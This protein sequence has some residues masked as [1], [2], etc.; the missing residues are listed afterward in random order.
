MVVYKKDIDDTRVANDT[1]LN[2][3]KPQVTAWYDPVNKEVLEMTVNNSWSLLT[4]VWPW[5]NNVSTDI[6]HDAWWRP[7]TILDK[8]IFHWLW[9]F[10][11]PY[12]VWITYEDWTEILAYNSTRITSANWW[13]DMVSWTTTWNTSLLKS[14]RNPRYQPNRW[15]LYSTAL[16]ADNV[17]T[18]I[19]RWWIANANWT[20]EDW[21]F[22]ELSWWNLYAVIYSEWVEFKKELIDTSW[23]QTVS[24]TTWELVDF[25]VTKWNL[26][27]IQ[28]QWRWVWDYLFF[29]NQKLVHVIRNLWTLT[30]VS[31]SNPWLSVMYY[32]E[33]TDWT[34]V[35]L[36]V[37]CVDVTSEWWQLEW[38][39]YTWI[40]NNDDVSVTSKS[41][42][43]PMI[44]AFNRTSF[45]WRTNTRDAQLLRVTIST[46]QDARF[47]IYVTRDSTAFTNLVLT[48]RYNDSVLQYMDNAWA[49]TPF[50]FDTTKWDA[51]Y[52]WTVALWNP[53]KIEN[54]IETIQFIVTP[55]DYIVVL[56]E[57]KSVNANMSAVMEF[58]EEI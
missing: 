8:S 24:P 34:E 16:R 11:V 25:D 53:F 19:R 10:D 38:L 22:F 28:F 47:L 48:D 35:S 15:H 45:K 55:W 57:K 21:T 9:T 50:T 51:L 54:P 18:W 36:W 43:V 49:A 37:W 4:S 1:Y 29:I 52:R 27:D 56:W 23:I 30:N 31:I 7:K 17:S 2:A 58:G 20:L 33:N 6:A 14:R 44:A 42:P 40:S 39:T 32:T 5:W 46:D 41:P 13:L 12:R 3:Y 26:Y